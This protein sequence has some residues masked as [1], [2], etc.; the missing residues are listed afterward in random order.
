M[1]RERKAS[2]ASNINLIFFSHHQS[3]LEVHSNSILKSVD[4]VNRKS[5]AIV[6]KRVSIVYI[7]SL[8]D[9]WTVQ[10]D[11]LFLYLSNKKRRKVFLKARLLLVQLV[12]RQSITCCFETSLTR[13]SYPK[14]IDVAIKHILSLLDNHKGTY[15]IDGR[16]FTY[17]QS[18]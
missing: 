8:K 17:S 4:L 10:Q 1:T 2:C 7:V 18:Q 13:S 16:S 5:C 15:A 14:K 3:L 6:C 12:Q 9:L 11:K